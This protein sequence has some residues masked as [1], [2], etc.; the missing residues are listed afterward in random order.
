MEYFPATAQACQSQRIFLEELALKGTVTTSRRLSA[1]P[2]CTGI[3][4]RLA[5][6]HARR[7]GL[8]LPPLLH[9]AGLTI[10]DIKDDNS[11]ITVEAQIRCLNLIAAALGDHLLG[12]H[13]A[14]QMDLRST[15]FLYYVAASSDTLGEAVMSI[16]RYSA[17]VNEGIDLKVKTGKVLAI[18]LGYAGVPRLA[19]RHQI[20]SWLVAVVRFCRAMAG[21]DLQPLGI[22]IMHQRI[23]ESTELDAFFGRAVDFG[24]DADDILFAV[25]ASKLP[26]ISADPYLNRL[27]IKYC[28]EILH[29]RK[30]PAD[31]LR[32]NVENAIA[33]LLPHGQAD[34]EK[35]AQR[36]G[37]TSRT[38]RRRLRSESLSF[39]RV[40][41]ELRIA[42]A[43]RYL[44]DRNLP[45]SRIA[46]LLGYSEISTFS[47]AFKR[48]TGRTPRAVRSQH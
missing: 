36:L 46:W 40:Q 2:T 14:R 44:A 4:T 45:I 19:D 12:F 13:I 32:P 16:A 38:L 37:I 20:E 6:A 11:P 35:V 34:I 3:M 39:A 31:A 28:D 24:A 27:L 15:G 18:N 30:F 10:N 7:L 26:N 48:W 29:H 25:E 42:L 33:A 9:R 23:P 41:R 43:R 47:H 5:C 8:S 22:K 21:R 17:I 1:I